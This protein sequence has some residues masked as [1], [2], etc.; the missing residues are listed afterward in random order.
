MLPGQALNAEFIFN[1]MATFRS[2]RPDTPGQPPAGFLLPAQW[3]AAMEAAGLADVRF[4]PDA[5]NFSDRFPRF[6]VAVIGATRP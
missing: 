4:I 6:H 2:R 5:L 1:L 3:K